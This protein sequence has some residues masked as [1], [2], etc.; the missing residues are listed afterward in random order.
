MSYSASGGEVRIKTRQNDKDKIRG[1]FDLIRRMGNNP[2]RCRYNNQIWTIN[3]NDKEKYIFDFLPD[4]LQKNGI[5]ITY[6][7][8]MAIF[9]K[10]IK[11]FILFTIN[12]SDSYKGWGVYVEFG[13]WENDEKRLKFELDLR[14]IHYP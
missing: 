1:V 5:E 13:R 8:R 14:E 4:G 6:K 2:Y 11:P 3:I 9:I 7:S 10:S 12:S